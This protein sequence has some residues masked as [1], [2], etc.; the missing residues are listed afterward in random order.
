MKTPLVIGLCIAVA[1]GIGYWIW[2]PP[3]PERP[4][5]ERALTVPDAVEAATADIAAASNIPADP[6]PGPNTRPGCTIVRHYLTQPDGTVVEA[7]SCEHD[8][9]PTPHPYVSYPRAALAS[10][11]YA[12][13]TAAEI[14][15]MRL[16]EEDAAESLSLLIR[17]AA[18]SGGD[19]APIRR[20]ASAY[21]HPV[22]IDGVPQPQTIRIKYVLASVEAL[23]QLDASM[24]NTGRQNRWAAV[25]REYSEDPERELAQLQTRAQDIVA[26]MRQIQLDVSGLST[27]GG[28][29]DA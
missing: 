15:G 13:A 22:F 11:A 3:A 24:P 12:D 7:L 23:L 29:G 18:L 17:A 8:I 14:L 4:G 20:Y 27:I 10:L 2:V 19:P 9:P 21:P 5:Q 28:A 16:I 1:A 6:S 26:E 25:I